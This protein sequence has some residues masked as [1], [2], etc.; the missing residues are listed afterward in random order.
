MDRRAGVLLF[1]LVL[2]LMGFTLIFPLVPD[3]LAYYVHSPLQPIDSY[4]P[5]LIQTLMQF[6]PDIGAGSESEIVMLGGI[7]ASVY[8]LLQFFLSPF[9]GRLSDRIGRR[10]VLLFTSIGMAL[11]YLLWVF[12]SSFTL[13][14]L[15]R[16]MAG[17]MAGNLGVATAAMADLSTEEGR[18]KSM[19][20]VGAA[21]GVGFIAGPAIGGAISRLDTAGL[22]LHYH[23]F[24]AAALL[25]VFLSV[26]SAVLNYFFLKET[27][28]AEHRIHGAFRLEYPFRVLSELK[29][30]VFRRMLLLNFVFMFLFTSFEFTV[31]FFYSID[32]G[33][34]PSQI[35]L[36]F[37]YLGFL[38]VFGQGFL[39]RK[40]SGRVSELRMII[41]GVLLIAFFLPLLALSAP[42]VPLSLLALA[43]V[44]I[45]SS[46]LQ[47]AMAGLASRSITAERQGLAMGSFR[48]MGSLARGIAPIF[49]SYLYG[50]M[51]IAITYSVIGALMLI[52]FVIGTGTLRMAQSE[53]SRT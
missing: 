29:E 36:V 50:S 12:S 3:L 40:L 9:W 30:T 13:F 31:T 46:L 22:P 48:S 32:F 41:A 44:A 10:P 35:G 5:V 42:Y 23:P 18:T 47:P 53:A 6:A 7:L 33:L 17:M 38:L 28:P 11:A 49:G 15:S 45:G 14:L 1:I 43:P 26:L 4:L 8:G 27:L 51:G 2:D 21:F 39:I 37:F 20:L 25:S 24:S 52:T 16:I 19:G 34:M